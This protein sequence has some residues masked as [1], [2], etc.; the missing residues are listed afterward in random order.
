MVKRLSHPSILD[1]KLK[2]CDSHVQKYIAQL[3]TQV[4]KLETDNAKLKVDEMRSKVR[5][6]FLETELSKNAPMSE[7]EAA[8][9]REITEEAVELSK[10]ELAQLRGGK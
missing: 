10:R 2:S 8:H 6:K 3:E 4:A 5:V 9:I 7:E 1:Q